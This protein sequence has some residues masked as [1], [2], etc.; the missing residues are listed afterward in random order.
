MG[1]LCVM[2]RWHI[3]DL[4]GR[5]LDKYPDMKVLRYAAIAEEDDWTVKDGLQA[6]RL[7]VGTQA[8]AHSSFVRG[9]LSTTANHCRRWP[10]AD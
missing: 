3:D 9:A 1:L 8:D 4:L 10:A 5:M 6:A 7:F 2:T